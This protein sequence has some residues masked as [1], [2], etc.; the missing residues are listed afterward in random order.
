MSFFLFFLR[1]YP[2]GSPKVAAVQQQVD[3]VT[4]IMRDNIGKVVQNME[5]TEDLVNKTSLYQFSQTIHAFSLFFSST[6]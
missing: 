1:G 2:I 3:Q 5:K 6:D 4:D